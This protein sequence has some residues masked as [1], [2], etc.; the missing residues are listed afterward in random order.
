VTDNV[1]ESKGDKS[2][3]AWKPSLSSFYCTYSRAWVKVKY[4]WKLTVTSAEKVAL[5]S[6]LATC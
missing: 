5:T 2:P 3:D 1:N 6:M 4:V